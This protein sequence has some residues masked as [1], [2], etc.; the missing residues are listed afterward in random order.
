MENQTTQ[1]VDMIYKLLPPNHPFVKTAMP[2]FVDSDTSD[3][4]RKEVAESLVE[5]M[6]HFGG[7][8]L[9][10]N[11]VGLPYR[12]FVMGDHKQ[13]ITCFNPKILSESKKTVVIEEGCLTYPGL[14]VKITRPEDIYVQFE[15]ENQSIHNTTFEGLMCRVYQHEMD[16][17][18]GIDFTSRAKRMD[19]NIAK[20]KLKRGKLK[21]KRA[22]GKDMLAR[23][24]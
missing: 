3:I 8:G 14:F 10:A 4:S 18:D 24:S 23:A 16:H 20:R 1:M 11:Q 13:Y 19:L 9:S 5:T 15:D 21:L 6:K 17:M 7:I 22:H 12:V 2:D